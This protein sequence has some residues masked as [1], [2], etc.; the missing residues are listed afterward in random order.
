[1]ETIDKTVESVINRMSKLSKAAPPTTDSEKFDTLIC[2][3]CGNV[4]QSTS[5]QYSM[6]GRY[7]ADCDD[8]TKQKR[9]KK[10]ESVCP[11]L[12]Q[13]TDITRLPQ[14]Q[15]QQVMR[16]EY[17]PRGLALIGETGKGKSR[18]A[19]SLMRRVMT[20]DQPDRRLVWFDCVGFGHAI[21]QHY[22]DE[23]AEEWLEKISKVE[24]LFFDDLGKLKLT[25]RAETELFGLI[26]RRCANQL[27]IIAT[28]NDSGDSLAAR[29]TENRGPAM[30][31]RLRE[32]C[33]VIRC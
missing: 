16:W 24:L 18:I 23:N 31:R 25:E 5:C 9:V 3:R 33:D 12:Y 14:T 17:G 8:C 20:E 26:E 1:M 19:W 6:P 32:F 30:I 21:A 22:K 11:K 10:F 27:P 7:T 13:N 15:F 4:R 28:T 29:M 2:G